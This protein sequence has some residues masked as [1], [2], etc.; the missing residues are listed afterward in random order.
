MDDVRV[1]A[2]TEERHP[3]TYAIDRVSTLEVL[4]LMNQ[5]D[6]TVADAVAAVLPELALLVDLAVEVFRML[7]DPTRVTLLWL[8]TTRE[9]SVNGLA[10]AAGRSSGCPSGVAGSAAARG[11][12]RSCTSSAAVRAREVS[13]AKTSTPKRAV[14][15]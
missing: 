14:P 10:V 9:L 5:A 1:S 12:R 15:R 13:G 4:T 11:A 8:L 6:R 3:G 2:P 7:A